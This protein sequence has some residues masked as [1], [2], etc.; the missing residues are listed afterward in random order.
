MPSNETRIG[1]TTTKM[2]KH[3]VVESHTTESGIQ[4]AIA[5]TSEQQQTTTSDSSWPQLSTAPPLEPF[6]EDDALYEYVDDDGKKIEKKKKEPV[7]NETTVVLIHEMRDKE[8]EAE[9]QKELE[10]N[11]IMQ[12]DDDVYDYVDMFKRFKEKTGVWRDK[13]RRHG[14]EE[15]HGREKRSAEENKEKAS[16]RG[17]D[18]S[19]T[20]W[21][22]QAK[23]G[24][25]TETQAKEAEEV[26]LHLPGICSTFTPA[27]VDEF[28]SDEFDSDLDDIGPIGVNLTALEE[29]GVDLDA[30]AKK[31]RND[32]EVDDILQRTA[33][34]TKH[35]GGSYILPVLNKNKYDPFSAP[36][37][38]QGS[39][40][41]VRFGI[42][43]ESM[44][45]FQ[46]TTMDYD[47][48]IYLLMSWRDARLVNRYDQPILVKEEEILEKIWRP[49]P[50]FANAKEAEFHEVTFLNFLMRIYSDGLVL[51]ETRVKITP[52]CN[53]I[54]C[55]YPHDKQTC[56]LMIKSFAYPVETVRFEW[57]TR[58]KD[59]IDKN[60][61]VKL[62]ELYID[63][64]EPTTCPS[65]RKSGEFSCLRAVFRLKRDVGFHIAQ[66]YIPTSL[67]LMF[68]WVGVWLPEEFMEGRI[69]V[70]ITVLLT[71]S[72]ESAGAREHL[73]SVSYL[74][75]I[76]LWFGFI[77]GF[78]FFTLLQTLFVIGFDK[79]SS[80]LKK[81]A[82]KKKTDLTEELREAL[83]EK[84]KRYHKTGRYLDNFC[85][86]FYPLSFVLF[87]IMYYFVF[88]EG[89]QIDQF[90]VALQ[91]GNSKHPK[92]PF[93][94]ESGLLSRNTRKQS[95]ATFADFSPDN[96]WGF[97]E[98][99]DEDQEQ[100]EVHEQEALKS[101]AQELDR[102]ETAKPVPETTLPPNPEHNGLLKDVGNVN[103]GF[104]VGVGVPGNDPVSVGTR[105]GLDLGASGLA[106]K[107]PIG[108][109]IF[110]RQGEQ[111][112][113]NDYDGNKALI[114]PDKWRKYWNAVYTGDIKIPQYQPVKSLVG[115]N[116]GIGI[117]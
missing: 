14:F 43:I 2:T 55:K 82:T 21:L 99:L 94:G 108:Q 77:T 40:V 60:P 15:E 1:E 58:R 90:P 12:Y 36:I 81:W 112:S 78:V 46:T 51:Y 30:L 62:P 54:L 10:T 88:T 8:R 34:S 84:A 42:Y 105:F 52:S 32:T 103:V 24:A 23:H 64:Y 16:D 83:L 87:L 106:G 26:G 86:V 67:A 48:D 71:L 47:M 37:V 4:T 93:T 45:N 56:D 91:S 9:R 110:P 49:D 33:N 85:R 22:N 79:R 116:S 68:S 31:L 89:R 18:E 57:F 61:D 19:E 92:N 3:D 80:Q 95:R 27:K 74:K 72:T 11:A 25:L 53:L 29:A 96:H 114:V 28:K 50:F 69:G 5:T 59:A 98:E 97:R 38:F 39:A 75:A 101:L 70:A 107:L 65:T 113:L 41:V 111:I 100:K 63:R 117:G 35:H 73:P 44:S 13:R 66:T 104:G 115:V 20:D 109:D 7:L 6:Y 76:D 102:A 17:E